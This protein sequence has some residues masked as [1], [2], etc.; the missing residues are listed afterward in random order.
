MNWGED[1]ISPRK[2]DELQAALRSMLER[3]RAHDSRVLAGDLA[4]GRGRVTEP[5]RYKMDT[6][7][8]MPFADQA[9]WK[10]QEQEELQKRFRTQTFVEM[11]E[12]EEGYAGCEGE[13][14]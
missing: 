8:T 5:L 7:W 10:P 13:P 11:Q 4:T 12:Q 1:F 3:G 6:P 2:V 14:Q 9:R